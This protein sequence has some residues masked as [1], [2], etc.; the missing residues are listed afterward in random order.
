MVHTNY[1]IG[2][3][4]YSPFCTFAVGATLYS[5]FC[6]FTAVKF[7]IT[8]THIHT[9]TQMTQLHSLHLHRRQLLV[10][11][12][13]HT[14]GLHNMASDM[15]VISDFRREADENCALL[16]YYAASGRNFLP[17]FRVNLSIPSFNYRNCVKKLYAIPGLFGLLLIE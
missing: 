7:I 9:H 4:L 13:F 12:C 14:Y 17:T 5:P 11:Q 3:I 15:C 2:T 1:A 16:G 10:P 8:Y 6:T